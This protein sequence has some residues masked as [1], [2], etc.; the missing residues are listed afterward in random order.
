M[1]AVTLGVEHLRWNVGCL[2]Y[3]VSSERLYLQKL[4]IQH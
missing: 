1:I 3:S 2:V 4:C